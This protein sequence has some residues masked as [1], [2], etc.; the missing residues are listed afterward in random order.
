MYENPKPWDLAI[1]QDEFT[2]NDSPNRSTGMSHFQIVYGMHPRGVYELR[3][4]GKQERRSAEG[5]EL[6]M[7]CRRISR[8]DYMKVQKI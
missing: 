1:S 3:Y 7:D 8:R 5:E 6:C 2:Y 4:L